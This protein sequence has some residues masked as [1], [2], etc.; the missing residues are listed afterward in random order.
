MFDAWGQLSLS[1][2]EVAALIVIVFVAGLVR[3]FSGFALSA[4]VMASAASF[5]APILLIPILWF[6]EISASLLMASGGWR[7]AN[8][9]RAALLVVGNWLGWPLGLWMTISLPVETSKRI[10]L[11]V[12]V[13]LAA[14]Q[15]L[16]VNIPALASRTGT[17]I[18]GVVAGIVSGVAH[19]GG[20][21]VALCVLSQNESARSMRGTLVLYLFAGSLGS[22]IYLIFFGVMTYTALLC[23]LTLIP[24]TLLGVWLGTKFFNPRWEPYYKPFCLCLLIGLA[25]FSLLRSLI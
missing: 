13:I 24:A 15:L 6:Q 9:K 23:A 21:V 16:K 7:D 11:T 12:I 25:A 4:L 17:L 8:R 20:M 14:L 18:T 5:V 2:G 3:G 1:S 19:V 10:A 22:L